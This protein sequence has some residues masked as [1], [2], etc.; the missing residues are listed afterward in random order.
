MESV[1][2][3]DAMAD[4]EANVDTHII[5]VPKCTMHNIPPMILAQL[6]S[7]LDESDRRSSIPHLYILCI[8]SMEIKMLSIWTVCAWIRSNNKQHTAQHT[9]NYTNRMVETVTLLAASVNSIANDSMICIQWDKIGW[10][11]K[12]VN[13]IIFFAVNEMVERSRCVAFI[14]INII[15]FN[16]WA[17]TKREVHRCAATIIWFCFWFF[18]ANIGMLLWHTLANGQPSSDWVI[19]HRN[20]WTRCWFTVA[21]S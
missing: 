14:N 18:F 11:H 3:I 8:H 12:H 5:Y 1:M 9:S 17:H 21:F 7:R 20:M 2:R 13:N 4:A 10:V 16:C 6:F 15:Q 19:E